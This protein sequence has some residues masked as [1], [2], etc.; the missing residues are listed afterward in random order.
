MTLRTYTRHVFLLCSLFS[1]A[2]FSA[3]QLQFQVQST[4]ETCQKGSAHLQVSGQYDSLY[5]QWSTVI[6]NQ[7]LIQVLEAGDYWVV[8]Y[9]STKHD[10]V[11]SIKDTTIRFTIA[12][13]PC[14]LLIPKYF[15]P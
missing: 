5:Y 3:Q 11:K 12:K 7:P 14:P 10:T 4:P 6:I 13:E 2:I 15:S 8:A 1:F 9:V